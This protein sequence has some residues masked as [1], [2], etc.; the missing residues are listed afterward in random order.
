MT[1]IR[2]YQSVCKTL[3]MAF[4][5][6]E[7]EMTIK[8]ILVYLDNDD[9]CAQRVLSAAQWC[10]YFD[11]HLTGLYA[12]RLLNIHHYPYAYLP[13]TAFEALEAHATE[14]CDEAKAVFVENANMGDASGEFRAVKG[15]IIGPLEIQSRYTDILVVPNQHANNKKMNPRYLVSDIL[16]AAAC[17]VLVLP[18]DHSPV[19]LPLQ[20]V[21]VAW[22][23]SHECARALKSALPM[24]AK[25][26]EVDVVSVSSNKQDAD[27]IAQHISRHGIKTNIH[28]VEGSSFDAGST[29]LKHA[30]NLNSQLIV[31]GA[32]G[33]SRL[34]EQVLGDAT[35]HTLHH[36]RLPILFSH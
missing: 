32:Y 30:E 14:Q 18:E 35:Q 15:E 23:G 33:H 34:R 36:A 10:H 20:R 27:D 6:E 2:N 17:P 5:Q 8:D 28:L 26:E 4:S 29:L 12:I 24:L 3:G 1:W 9:D 16:L 13:A 7:H 19:T 22:D 31:M 11:A 21:L 25:T